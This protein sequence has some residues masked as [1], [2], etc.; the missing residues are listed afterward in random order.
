MFH[1]WMKV[2][3]NEGQ[4]EANLEVTQWSTQ[5]ALHPHPAHPRTQPALPEAPWPAPQEAPRGGYAGGG[6]TLSQPRPYPHPVP[7]SA[8]VGQDTSRLW[9]PQISWPLSP[10]SLELLF[11][12]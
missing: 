8:E 10:Y 12:E 11:F 6:G 2:E 7:D 4:R 3:M 5:M 1:K 9:P